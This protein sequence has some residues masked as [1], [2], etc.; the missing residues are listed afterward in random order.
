MAENRQVETGSMPP[1]PLEQKTF[2]LTRGLVVAGCAAGFAVQQAVRAQANVNYG[3]AETA[4]LFALTAVFWLFA[5]GALA[6]G[7]T[8]SGA[9]EINVTRRGS[10]RKMTLVIAGPA[11]EADRSV[12]AMQSF[13]RGL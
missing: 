4:I 1:R 10:L 9:H 8:G 12:L 3:L 7:R 13:L 11:E 5:L 6:F 2:W